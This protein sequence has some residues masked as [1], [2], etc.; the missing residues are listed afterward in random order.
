MGEPVLVVE[1]AGIQLVRGIYFG[2]V[3]VVEEAGAEVEVGLGKMCR[4]DK[5][6]VVPEAVGGG[7]GGGG[8]GGAEYACDP[9]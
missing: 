1:L 5:K 2:L 7:G 8:G 3:E 6:Q 9:I 4:Q